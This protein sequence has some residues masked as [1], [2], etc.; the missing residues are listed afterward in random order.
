MKY[1]DYFKDPRW[2][3][4]R[5]E[6]LERDG[7]ACQ[8]CYDTESTLHVH[9][10]YYEK[11]KKPWE[12]DNKFL[13][14]LCGSCHELE[15][16]QIK[17]VCDTLLQAVKEKFFAGDILDIAFGFSQLNIIYDSHVTSSIVGHILSSPQI[18]EKARDSY[19]KKIEDNRRRKK[20]AKRKND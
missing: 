3:K 18:L 15:T 17:E 19:F 1:A 7:F 12:Y 6:I 5:L 10:R 16:T 4:K 14:T 9:H 8:I 20:N 2:Q 13:V 11:D